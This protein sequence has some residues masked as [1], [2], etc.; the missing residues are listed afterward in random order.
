MSEVKTGEEIIGAILR[1]K[2]VC[3]WAHGDGLKIFHSIEDNLKDKIVVPEEKWQRI[4]ALMG[5][6]PRFSDYIFGKDDYKL[7]L[8]AKTDYIL[9]LLPWLRKLREAVEE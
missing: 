8:E 4:K 2:D 6:E 3:F 9:A 7:E 1:A 5:N